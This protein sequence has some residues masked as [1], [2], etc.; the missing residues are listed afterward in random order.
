[1]VKLV[2]DLTVRLYKHVARG[3]FTQSL[4]K[5]VAC[6]P[7]SSCIVPMSVGA[8]VCLFLRASTKYKAHIPLST[9]VTCQLLVCTSKF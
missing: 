8:R 3:L 1:M 9:R 6:I 5:L 7:S 2:F 4:T